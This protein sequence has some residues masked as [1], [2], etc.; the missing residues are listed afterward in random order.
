M[1]LAYQ[2]TSKSKKNS[3]EAILYSIDLETNLA[4]LY[5]A[6]KHNKYFIG[7]Y[8]EFII[9]EPKLRRIRSLPYKDRI[10]HQWYVGEFIKPFFVP[11]F[12]KDSYACID[13]RRHIKRLKLYNIT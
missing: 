12:I 6:I 10:V 3:K 7:K 5:K 13:G 9:Y 11:R 8:H 1:Y 2:R 4:N